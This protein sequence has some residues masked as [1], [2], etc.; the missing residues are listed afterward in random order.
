MKIFYARVQF[1]DGR[2]VSWPFPTEDKART[3]IADAIVLNL[4]AWKGSA[5]Y[6]TK[7]EVVL[8]EVDTP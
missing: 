5:N 1:E 2:T 4:G 7:F 6:P 8:E 3:A